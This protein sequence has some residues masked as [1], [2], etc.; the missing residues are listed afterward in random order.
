VDV[1]SSVSPFTTLVDFQGFRSGFSVGVILTAVVLALGF[2]VTKL[3][4]RTHAPLGF[5]GPAWVI[6][7][8]V[9]I[10]GSFGYQQ[11]DTFPRGLLWGLVVLF[12]AGELADRT[13]NPKIIGAVLAVPGAVLV[14]I[15]SDFPGPSWS[16]NLVIAT[17]IVASPLAAD[18]DRRSARLGLGPVL[19][20]IA[21]AGLYWTVPD[22]ER[23][24]PL[25]GA[26]VP[27][28][29]TGWP[30]R[31]SRMGAGGIS[32]CIALFMWV[33]AFEGRGRPGSI[34][35]AAASLG[36][37]VVEP[38]GRGLAKGRIASLSRSIGLGAFEWSV[39]GAQVVL[40]GYASRVAG[41]AETGGGALVLLVPA[42][43][44]AVAVGGVVRVSKRL[45]PGR[46][47]ATSTRRRR[48]QAKS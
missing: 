19:W 6:A 20:L 11:I 25:I 32:A 44:V 16:R 5:T 34:V 10:G 38:V 43:P 12:A 30:K 1:V 27:L 2:G 4:R 45:R 31:L 48:S 7:V 8:V 46:S 47:S 35:G 14:G 26:A 24:R 40:V 23:V 9:V 15:S 36:L 13:P 29:F 18:L 37:F 41:F 3:P 17:I 21:V 39:V 28:A 33:A 22:T 42:I